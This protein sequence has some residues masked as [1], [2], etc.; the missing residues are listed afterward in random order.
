MEDQ[1]RNL[2][3]HKAAKAAM[4]I[5]NERYM[6]FGGGSM[7]FW[8]SLSESEKQIARTCVKEIYECVPE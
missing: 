6:A 1:T 8:D 3:P 4:W 7:D 2:N 5:W